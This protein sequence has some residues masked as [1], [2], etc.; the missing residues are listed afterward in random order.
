MEEAN[1]AVP[2]AFIRVPISVSIGQEPVIIHPASIM[3]CI[4][5]SHPLVD[6]C[7]KTT[8]PTP[9]IF[10]LARTLAER[11]SKE[12]KPFIPVYPELLNHKRPEFRVRLDL[13]SGKDPL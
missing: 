4:C 10:F 3:A 12:E 13:R 1:E 9:L 5:A 6:L 7:A 8:T 11:F 2:I